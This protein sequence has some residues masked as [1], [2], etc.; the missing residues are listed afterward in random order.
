M[1]TPTPDK[2]TA[3]APPGDRPH[4]PVAFAPYLRAPEGARTVFVVTLIAACAPLVA[5][6]ILFGWRAAVVAGISIVSC[7]TIERLY[8]RVTRTPALFFRSHAYLTGVLLA[9]TLPAFV[10][11]YI[12]VVAAAF[13]I[14]VGKAIFGG[15]GHFLWQPALVGRVAVGVI[16]LSTLTPD[17]WPVLAR[18]NLIDGDIRNT[19]RATDFRQWTGRPAPLGADGFT[20][21]TPADVLS[22]LTRAEQ[23]PYSGLADMARVAEGEPFDLP[24]TKPLP[25]P[26]AKPPVLLRLPPLGEMLYGT[27]PGGIGE[28]CAL[29][30]LVAGLYLVYRNYVKWALPLSFV[31]AAAVVIA[32]G[33]IRLIHRGDMDADWVWL[34][35]LYE[36]LDVGFTYI[37]YQLL[38]TEI[39]L[40]A[41]FLATEMTTRPVTTG[42]QVLFGIG[43]GVLAMMLRL[44]VDLPVPCYT[45]VL[46]MNTFTQK[47]DAAWRPRALGQPRLGM[48]LLKRFRK[49]GATS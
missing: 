6:I 38:S 40:T 27:R 7:A 25:L 37:N 41:F 20:V 8:Y 10:P 5:G 36:G 23:T 44:Y 34:P 35:L 24:E 21:M 43:C 45:A 11:W 47:I 49:S 39:L 33:P 3:T 12:P 16:F 18:D 4:R 26:G 1:T 32:I 14:I 2:P 17:Y 31:V 29:V 42:G 9:L 46:I 30:I 13:A 22:G 19:R 48:A 28:T 15:V